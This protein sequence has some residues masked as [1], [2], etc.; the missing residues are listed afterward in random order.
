MGTA[1]SPAAVSE[2]VQRR[3]RRA[4]LEGD[5][6]GTSLRSAFV[7]D[8][9]VREIP[10]LAVVA[11]TEHRAA[12]SVVGYFRSAAAEVN[13]ETSLLECRHVS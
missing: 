2:T 10:L 5:F 6:G 7:T 12:R 3:A 1:A 13:R 11:M 9:G 8:A 4:E